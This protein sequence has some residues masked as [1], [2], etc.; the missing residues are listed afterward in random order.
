MDARDRKRIHNQL[1]RIERCLGDAQDY[2]ARN[3]NVE[4]RG[5]LHLDDWRGKS[6][7][8]LWMKNFMIPSLI[9]RRAKK[10]KLLDRID[11][12]ANDRVIGRR[13]RSAPV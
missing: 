11:A 5:F 13:R 6:G 4:G 10:E 8:P 7:H 12:Q 9:K 2:V 3:V 1:A